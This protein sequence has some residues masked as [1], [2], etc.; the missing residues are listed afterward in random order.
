VRKHALAPKQFTHENDE[1]VEIGGF[2]CGK[3]SF[4]EA[5]VID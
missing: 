3:F 2:V 1:C 5:S 4:F